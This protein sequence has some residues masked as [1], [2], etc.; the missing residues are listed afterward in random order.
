MDDLHSEY[1]E[2]MDRLQK[3]G[4]RYIADSLKSVFEPYVAGRCGS[5]KQG[6]FD[7][8]LALGL[9]REA[10]EAEV[11]ERFRKLSRLLHPDTAACPGT[12]FLFNLVNL[13]YRLIAQERGWR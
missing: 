5:P 7:A 3:L 6:G 11:K 13:S 2:L 12:E 4:E 8:Y 10:T 9:S 1:A